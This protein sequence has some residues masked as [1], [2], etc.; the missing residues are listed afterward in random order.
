MKLLIDAGAEVN[1]E[2]E[3]YGNALQAASAAGHDQLIKLLLDRTDLTTTSSM[4]F[5]SWTPL[6]GSQCTA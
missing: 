5:R 3:D 4:Y 6:P 2:D 1:T